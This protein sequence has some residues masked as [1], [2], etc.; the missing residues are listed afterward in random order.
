MYKVVNGL[1]HGPWPLRWGRAAVPAQHSMIG[2]ASPLRAVSLYQVFMSVSPRRRACGR[3]GR[4]HD[5]ASWPASTGAN[6][7]PDWQG[8]IT[9]LFP[10]PRPISPA[11]KACISE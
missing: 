2:T 5:G 7:S 4:Q 6:G 9:A 3:K 8:F 11:R 10:I 1:D